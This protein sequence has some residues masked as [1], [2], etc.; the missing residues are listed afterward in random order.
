MGFSETRI[1]NKQ[2]KLLLTLTDGVKKLIDGIQEF[3]K[4]LVEASTATPHKRKSTTQEKEVSQ[5][6]RRGK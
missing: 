2:G 6:K 5:Q 1:A 3:A 4:S